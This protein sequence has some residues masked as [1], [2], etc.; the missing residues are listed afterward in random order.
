MKLLIVGSDKIFAIENFYAKYI[1]EFGNEVKLF[2]AQSMFF[3]YY[4]KSVFNKVKFR[5]GVSSITKKI[6]EEFLSVVADF[7]PEVIWV[8]KGMEIT[9]DSL[10]WAKSRGIKLVNY[11]PDNPFIFSSRGSGNSNVTDSIGLY[12]LH[13]TYNLEVRKTILDHFRIR[14]ELLPF[15]YDISQSLY[16]SCL[17][18]EEV[19]RACFLG[20]PD[21]NRAKFLLAL[22]GSGIALDVYGNDWNTFLNHKNVK[23]FPAVY[24]DALWKTLRKYRVQLNLMRVHN[25]DSHNMRSFEVPAI[26]GVMLA[27]DTPEHRMYFDDDKEIFL[28]RNADECQEK[29]HKLINAK[30]EEIELVRNRARNRSL[31]SGYSY[32]DRACQAIKII[33]SLSA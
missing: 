19:M 10:K 4:Q 18:Q 12:D 13:F 20:N 27:P 11:N 29:I 2:T 5:L 9:P 14:T 31:S 16:E 23:V 32:R 17:A 33:Q 22:A 25:E 7:Q 21:E 8:F 3:D 30:P 24:G 28:F 6:N 26:G 15:G 1:R